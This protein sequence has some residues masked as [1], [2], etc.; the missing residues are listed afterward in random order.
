[1]VQAEHKYP[2]NK[3]IDI[4]GEFIKMELASKLTEGLVH[5]RLVQFYEER[6]QFDNNIKV[7]ARLYV[8]SPIEE[9]TVKPL[10]YLK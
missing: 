1:M 7:V 5:S 9:P 4:N 10:E 6:N 8:T 3:L 2:L